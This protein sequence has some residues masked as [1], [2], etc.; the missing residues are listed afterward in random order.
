MVA[1]ARPA[2]LPLPRTPLIGR[3]SILAE[4][5][6]LLLRPDI[7]LVTLTG[8]GGVGKTRLALAVA[9]SLLD[10]VDAVHFIRLATLRDPALVL[11]AIA[12]VLDV[13]EVADRPLSELIQAAI[14]DRT[15]LLVL[16]NFEQVV[17]TANDLA[18]LLA[19]CRNLTLLV[20]SRIVL[21]LSG[22][23]AFPVPPLTMITPAE[24]A[25]ADDV[26]RSEAGTLFVT[27]ATAAN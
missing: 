8:P 9:E 18:P 2:T 14:D 11:P 27:R 3:E 17:D 7:P 22:E 25:T 6:A 12:Q 20:T 5:R 16:D 4:I 1:A 23:Q 10:D 15:V 19:N 21:H 26:T 24:R 13:R